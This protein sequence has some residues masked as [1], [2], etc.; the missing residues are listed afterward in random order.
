MA[1][2]EKYEVQKKIQIYLK[3]FFFS[4]F[5]ILPSHCRYAWGI[6]HNS[7][8]LFICQ[9]I[10]KHIVSHRA[11]ESDSEVILETSNKEENDFPEDYIC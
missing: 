11:A 7:P 10:N 8:S 9:V 5:K 6:C 4:S 3:E 1:F 2:L